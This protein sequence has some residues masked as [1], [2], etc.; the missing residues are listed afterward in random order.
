MDS[1][2]SL[3]DETATVSIVNGSVEISNPLFSGYADRATEIGYR[4]NS[5]KDTLDILR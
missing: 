3:S 1:D 5:P 2:F 4:K